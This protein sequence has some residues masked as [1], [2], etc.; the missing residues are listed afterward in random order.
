MNYGNNI[1]IVPLT[2]CGGITKPFIAKEH[3]GVDIGWWKQN[4]CSVLAWQ[5]GKVIAKGYY[6]DTGYYVALEHTY[7]TTKRWT[8]YIHLLSGS[9]GHLSV[10]QSVKMGQKIG[11]RGNTG[12]SSGEHLHLYLTSEI[13]KKLKFSFKNLRDHSVN[14][15]PYLYYSK[16]YNTIYISKDWKKP[17]PDP[18][19]DVVQPVERDEQK[20]QLICHEADLRVRTGA[21][22][23]KEVLGYLQKDKYYDWF[24]TTDAEGYTWFKLADNQWCAKIK[25]VDVLPKQEYY[26]AQEGDTLES[27]AKKFSI[28]LEELVALNPQLVQAG[29]EIRIS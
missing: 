23:S 5:D 10:G 15:V 2:D 12:H 17:L 7:P 24:E 19:P 14:P 16:E 29:D 6:S 13:T 4:N 27:I 1:G 11:R 9:T 20:D 25:S 26:T 21:S 22:L 8:C 3:F 28:T 18:L